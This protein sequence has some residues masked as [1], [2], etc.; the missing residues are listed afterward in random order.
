MKIERIDTK[1]DVGKKIERIVIS[2]HGVEYTITSDFLG[3]RIHREDKIC[4][5]PGCANEIIVK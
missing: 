4:V 2:N 3:I 1:K 5:F